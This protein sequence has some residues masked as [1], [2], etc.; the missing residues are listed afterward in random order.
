MIDDLINSNYLIGKN[1][2]KIEDIFGKPKKIIKT[3]D[4]WNYQL[5]GRTWA[6][7]KIIN[8]KLYFKN[9]TIVEFYSH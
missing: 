9:D 1:K 7:F 8:L 5:V 3:Q 2:S 6:D 4:I